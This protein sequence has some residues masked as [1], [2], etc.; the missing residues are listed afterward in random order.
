MSE[1]ELARL[2]A[3]GAAMTL[4]EAVTYALG[5]RTADLDEQVRA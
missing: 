5:G 2:S 4:D 3:E 1:A